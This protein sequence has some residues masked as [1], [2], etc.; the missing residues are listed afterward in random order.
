MLL[1]SYLCLFCFFKN[2]M[3][4]GYYRSEEKRVADWNKHIIRHIPGIYSKIVCAG[5]CQVEQKCNSFKLNDNNCTLAGPINKLEEFSEDLNNPKHYE[6][7]YLEDTG[8]PYPKKCW[9]GDNC[10]NSDNT[11]SWYWRDGDCDT[12][13]DC[14]GI[15]TVC[16]TNNCLIGFNSRNNSMSIRAVDGLKGLWDETDD[17]CTKRCTPENP[18][19]PGIFFLII[20]YICS[21]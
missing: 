4:K 1:L 10:C 3:S 18:C 21:V 8:K 12:D 7:F 2:S 20:H 11:C 19:Q 6:A 17:C 14:H 9:G 15:G 16:G 13:N 5:L